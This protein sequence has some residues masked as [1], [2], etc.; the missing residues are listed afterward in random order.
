MKGGV[1][2]GNHATVENGVTATAG[3]GGGL[4]MVFR[5]SLVMESG[6]ISGNTADMDGGGV[7]VQS[8]ASFTMEG[9][10]ISDN[11]AGAGSIPSV[12]SGGGVF[13]SNGASFKMTGGSIAANTAKDRGGGVY[14]H[15]SAGLFLVDGGTIYANG[16]GTPPGKKNKAQKITDPKGHAIYDNRPATPVPY[17]DVDISVFPIP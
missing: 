12:G 1:I 8:S 7:H 14:M 3:F 10:E 4:S 11:M 13:S 17:D 9:G 5:S 6:S 15:T 2:S 16:P